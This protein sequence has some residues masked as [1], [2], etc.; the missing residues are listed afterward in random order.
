MKVI[1]TDFATESLHDIYK[2]YEEAASSKVAQRIKTRI[3]SVTRQLKHHP[4]SG[5][6]EPNLIPLG[7]N[8]RYLVEG[9]YKVIYKKV[10]E[11]ILVTD[12]FDTRQDPTKMIHLKRKPRR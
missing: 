6:I 10:S 3:F 12:I 7:E 2:Y 9:N 11:G 5:Q 1:W 8:H 4:D